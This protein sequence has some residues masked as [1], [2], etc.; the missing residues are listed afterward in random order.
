MSIDL[1]LA[2]VTFAIVTTVTPGPN[3]LMLMASGVNFGF[4]RSIPHI[5]GIGLGFPLMIGLIGMG[6]GRLLEAWPVVYSA[7]KVAGIAYLLWFAWRL[8]NAGPLE[9]GNSSGSP[10]SFLQGAAF[11]WVNPKAWL[12]GVAAI[13]AYTE[14]ANYWTALLIVT[15]VFAGAA[16]P[17]SAVWVGFGTALRHFMSDPRHYRWVNIT[18]AV[19]LVLSLVPLVIH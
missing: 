1:F 7:L 12:M 17:S 16:F 2:L 6:L 18:M 19:L 13:A 5:L 8:A 3:N 9:G 11:Q 10:L 14:T 15:M 4:R